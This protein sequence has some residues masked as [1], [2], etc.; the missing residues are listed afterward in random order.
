MT[1]T[2]PLALPVHTGIARIDLR[3]I[4]VISVTRSPFTLASQTFA[5]AGQMWQADVVLPPMKRADAEQWVAWLVSLR[6]QY[7]TFLLGDPLG[8]TARGVAT[9]TPLV[10]GAGQ[11]GGSLIIDGAGAGVT[12]WLKAGDYIQL[13]S[14]SSATLHKVLADANSDGSG[15]VTL[16][17]WPHIRIAPA[18]N[19]TVVVA[20]PKG[21]FRLS[22]N[23]QAWS[24]NEASV[25][26]LA[27]GAVEV[28]V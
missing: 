10:K 21:L 23:E 19:A 15:N 22:G 3:A 11:T 5:H 9:G 18:D 8:A 7:G 1:I 24:I 26:G 20:A 27:F 13:G 16:D 12:G 6:G 2:Y 14:A 28:I 25:Y 4:N 17:I